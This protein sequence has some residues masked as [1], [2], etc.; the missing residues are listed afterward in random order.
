MEKGFDSEN[1][2]SIDIRTANFLT[3]KSSSLS[4]VKFI[5]EPCGD[6][7]FYT[8]KTSNFKE[9]KLFF[10]RKFSWNKKK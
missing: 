7:N 1:H 3:D 6:I 10:K 8:D 2:D 5:F 4:R 9:L